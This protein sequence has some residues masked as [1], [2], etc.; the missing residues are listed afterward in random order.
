MINTV[1]ID[2]CE[3]MYAGRD[4]LIADF[5]QQYQQQDED[6]GDDGRSGKI[7]TPEELIEECRND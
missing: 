6:E 5:K 7:T 1:T 4:N 2:I 3:L